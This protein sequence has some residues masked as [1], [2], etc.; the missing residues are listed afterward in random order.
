MKIIWNDREPIYVQLYQYL[1]R[2]IVEQV[3]DEGEALPSVRDIASEQRVNPITVSR[4]IQLLVDDNI[5]EKRRGLGMFV[6][7]GA[8]AILKAQLR[9]NFLSDE[10]PNIRRRIDLLGLSVEQLLKDTDL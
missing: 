1:A 3:I 8:P 7:E 4:A 10:W 5:V 6:I 2:L 9:Q